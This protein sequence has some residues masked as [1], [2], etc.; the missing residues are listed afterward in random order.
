MQRG[1]DRFS[2]SVHSSPHMFE[3]SSIPT[4]RASTKNRSK[5]EHLTNRPGQA[6]FSEEEISFWGCR[7]TRRDGRAFA[8]IFKII[9]GLTTSIVLS[10]HLASAD[11]IWRVGDG[12]EIRPEITG[13]MAPGCMVHWSRQ[14]GATV[15]I[16][17]SGSAPEEH[18]IA[19]REPRTEFGQVSGV[20]NVRY[21]GYNMGIAVGGRSGGSIPIYELHIDTDGGFL[22]YI[23]TYSLS[24]ED[25]VRSHFRAFAALGSI[26]LQ[27]IE[28]NA[29]PSYAELALERSHGGFNL[30]EAE[31]ALSL[32]PQCL[33][34]FK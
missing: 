2:E 17:R 22:T 32:L 13:P 5:R 10:T 3:M 24:T 15:M 29:P 7:P 26:E 20:F 27:V 1:E 23:G 18:F 21:P 14:D 16:G 19:L 11:E 25:T 30:V 34:D 31:L 12:W 33:S 4:A 9:L 6:T 8:M 28:V